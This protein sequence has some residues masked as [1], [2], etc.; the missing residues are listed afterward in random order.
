MSQLTSKTHRTG[1]CISR[2]MVLWDLFMT[3]A[4]YNLKLKIFC[5]NSQR[6]NVSPINLLFCRIFDWKMICTQII[7]LN[8]EWKY[9]VA[10]IFYLLTDEHNFS[11]I[12]NKKMWFYISMGVDIWQMLLKSKIAHNHEISFFK[13]PESQAC[14][15]FIFCLFD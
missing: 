12:I 10:F 6:E 8:S 1:K 4:L 15:I 13:C 2:R 5:Y 11:S 7:Y 3:V 9:Y 14:F